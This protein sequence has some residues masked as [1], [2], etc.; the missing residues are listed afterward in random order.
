MSLAERMLHYLSDA[1][2]IEHPKQQH[3]LL[4]VSGGKDS[5]VMAHFF[6]QT[7]L[8]FGIGHCNFQLRGK[9]AD[10]DA[11]FVEDLAR[12]LDCPFHQTTFDTLALAE[13]SSV[14]VQMAARELRYEWL[15]AVRESSGYGYVATA[16]HLTD[17][18]ETQF[19]HLA[20]GTGL[21]GLLGI[22]PRNGQVVR[23]LLFAS[24]SEITDYQEAQGLTYRED[25][26][27]AETK[28]T[29]NFIRHRI[30]PVFRELNPS[31][32]RSLGENMQRFR[33]SAYL[34][35]QMLNQ[36]EKTAKTR[37]GER[38]LYRLD[39]LKAF[40][41]ALPTV[42]FELLSSFGL[43][44]TQANDLSSAIL[45]RQPGR[46]FYTPTHE[47]ALAS[48]VL[49]VIAQKPGE[50]KPLTIEKEVEELD[51]PG[52]RLVFQLMKQV[53]ETFSED[54]K[55]AYFDFDTLAF[56]LTL[57][58]WQAGD[59]FQP[60]GMNGKHQ[61]IQDYFSDHKFTRAE[62]AATWIM[63]DAGGVVLWVTGHRSSHNSR[64]RSSTKKCWKIRV[65][66]D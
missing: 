24:R 2:G 51:F 38:L 22:P 32:E 62:K 35:E 43:N 41:P 11:A 58:K 40:A 57:R 54:P 64:V 33:E 10:E 31:L 56:P 9:A 46:V 16:H 13:Q 27:N 17:A 1:C 49:E 48:N 66:F 44:T 7:G 29:R 5:V 34:M 26:S 36:I 65:S 59:R 6:A 25:R 37:D 63:V 42:L 61:K 8:S 28:Y 3:F 55:V 39:A 47:I 23:P 20:R 12:Q 19:F 14:S 53:P 50:T 52:G 45:E 21:K 4:A 18:I 30:L 15:E 60:F